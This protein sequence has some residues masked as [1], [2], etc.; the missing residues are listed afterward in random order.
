L[1]ETEYISHDSLVVSHRK[2]W[3]KL[4]RIHGKDMGNLTELFRKAERARSGMEQ[5][6]RQFQRLRKQKEAPH[7]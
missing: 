6:I 3:Y 5:D 7:A 1:D 2:P 4:K